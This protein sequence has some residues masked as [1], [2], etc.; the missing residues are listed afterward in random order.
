MVL[1]FDDEGT[2]GAVE[3]TCLGT[4]AT[5]NAYVVDGRYTPDS[6]LSVF[7]TTP[8]AGSYTLTISDLA[9][10]DV[11]TLNAWALLITAGTVAGEGSA[12]AAASRMVVAP[13]P[14]AGQGQ[15]D[16]TVATAQDVRVVLFDALGRE[17]QVLLDRAMAAGQQA[18]IGFTTANLPA[19]VYVVR[20]SGTDVSL[21]QRVTVVR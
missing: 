13:N 18:Y 7:N 2:D 3:T 1:T 14:L 17:V 6:P 12:T 5:D 21:T 8:S 11:G 16:L 4:V 10:P 15:I 9:T 19:G 20:A